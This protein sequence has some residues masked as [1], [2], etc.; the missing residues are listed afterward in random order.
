MLFN[1]FFNFFLLEQD[2]AHIK[3]HILVKL[4]TLLF[5]FFNHR[6]VIVAYWANL[7]LILVK[8]IFCLVYTNVFEHCDRELLF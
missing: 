1:L 6:V 2:Y 3:F 7:H 4:F 5:Y 8:E